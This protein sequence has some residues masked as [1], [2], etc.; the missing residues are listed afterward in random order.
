MDPTYLFTLPGVSAKLAWKD[1]ISIRGK[2]ADVYL[3]KDKAYLYIQLFSVIA[4]KIS[5][6]FSL[7]VNSDQDREVGHGPPV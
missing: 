3:I 1:K 5:T 2:T 6:N 7:L 4:W